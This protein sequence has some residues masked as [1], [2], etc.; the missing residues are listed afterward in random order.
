MVR[1]YNSGKFIHLP[2]PL[3]CT[4]LSSLMFANYLALFWLH[5]E[6]YSHSVA[7]S[8]IFFHDDGQKKL[9]IM[10]L[11]RDELFLIFTWPLMLGTPAL[12][13]LVFLVLPNGPNFIYYNIPESMKN[14]WTMLGCGVLEGYVLTLESKG[15]NKSKEFR[16]QTLDQELKRCQV[17]QLRLKIFNETNRNLQC[18]HN[19]WYFQESILLGYFGIRIMLEDLVLGGSFLSLGLFASAV[20]IFTYEPAFGIPDK[21][22]EYKSSLKELASLCQDKAR[23]AMSMMTVNSVQRTGIKVGKVLTLNR[24]TPMLFVDFVVQ[25]VVSLLLAY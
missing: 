16:Q 4:S 9:K 14:G 19:I 21:I 22:E 10:E 15:R 18:L 20:Y 5:P 24:L 25:N 13:V 6:F 17:V 23:L 8:L 12:H 3:A 1:E 7:N 11:N 2:C